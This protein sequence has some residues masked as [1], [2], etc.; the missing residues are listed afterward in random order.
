MRWLLVAAAAAVLIGGG[1]S[2]ASAQNATQSTSVNVQATPT[3]TPGPSS[4]PG[5][6]STPKPKKTPKPKEPKGGLGAGGSGGASGGSDVLGSSLLPK[7]GVEI[8]L[9][10][11]VGA[12]LLALGVTLVVVTRRRRLAAKGV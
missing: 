6:T 11:L 12:V 4:S 7:T 1:L 10:T 3:D 5:P 8:A 9:Y 2:V